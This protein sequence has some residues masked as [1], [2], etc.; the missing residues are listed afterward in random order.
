[1]DTIA[2]LART[3]PVT[4]DRFVDLLRA[5]SIAVVVLGHWLLAVVAFEG[6]VFTG[7][8]A[9]AVVPWAQWLTWGLQVMPLF[10]F[11][12]GFGNFVAWRSRRDYGTFVRSRFRRLLGPTAVF[13]G[14]WLAT[15]VAIRAAG[16]ST[17]F[18]AELATLVAIPLWFLGVYLVV[19]LMAPALIRAHERYGARVPLALLAGAAVVDG[20][21]RHFGAPVGPL[22]YALV[23]LVPHQLGFLLA[24]GSFDRA[25]RAAVA[26]L[27]AI[28]AGVVVTFAATGLYPVSMVGVP[29]AA[30]SNNA[31][32]TLALAMH[33]LWMVGLALLARPAVN[34]W[35]R[36]ERPW[37]AV[38]AANTVVMTLFLWHMTALVVGAVVLFPAGLPQPEPGSGAWWALRPAWMLALAAFLAV[39]VALFARLE[40][41]SLRATRPRA[42]SSRTTVAGALLATGGMIGIAI[43]G[44]VPGVPMLA[45]A[46]GVATLRAAG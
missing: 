39:F 32:P 7:Q 8:N 14:V 20:A 9:L 36:R 1:M 45:L 25:G 46:V 18:S 22:N 10:F 28:G 13:A 31:P 41:R 3:T 37:R 42:A 12:G 24:D 44:L 4:R 40:V 21:S 23:W 33:G 15:V 5:A 35:L 27:A 2:T 30:D 34:R 26:G 38:V 17:G 43:G 6:G 16:V 19:V 29:G 11:A